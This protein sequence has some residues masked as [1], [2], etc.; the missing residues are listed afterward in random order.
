VGEDTNGNASYYNI[1][2]DGEDF[3]VVYKPDIDT[4][5]C[6]CMLFNKIG[7][8]CRHILATLKYMDMK[9][10]PNNLVLNRWTKGAVQNAKSGISDLLWNE[11]VEIQEKQML[12]NEVWS[13]IYNC[14]GL[15]E[16]DVDKLK[17]LLKTLKGKKDLYK[18]EEHEDENNI[19]VTGI[20]NVHIFQYTKLYIQ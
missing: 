8:P 9:E 7:I 5:T 19:R 4:T 13:L 16:N 14:V 20:Y 18:D 17:D 11:T 6:S 3:D 1:K 15:V 10:I 12:L 2:V